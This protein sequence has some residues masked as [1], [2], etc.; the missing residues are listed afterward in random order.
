MSKEQIAL[1]NSKSSSGQRK[2][3][4]LRLPA[5]LITRRPCNSGRENYTSEGP[6]GYVSQDYQLSLL[7]LADKIVPLTTATSTDI[8]KGIRVQ[9]SIR[10][11][12]TVPS[13]LHRSYHRRIFATRRISDADPAIC[14]DEPSDIAGLV[15][16]RRID[17]NVARSGDCED[18][19]HL[20]PHLCKLENKVYAKKLAELNYEFIAK[21]TANCAVF[22]DFH[23]WALEYSYD[24]SHIKDWQRIHQA[25]A[26]FLSEHTVHQDR[27]EQGANG[28]AAI[29]TP[30]VRQERLALA[31]EE[32][33]ALACI[34]EG[35]VEP[36]TTWRTTP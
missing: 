31:N 4:V 26:Q 10:N 19:N 9:I 28:G 30:I 33:S 20:A 17:P 36:D 29:S 22:N 24:F 16:F 23:G 1:I 2:V 32:V 21:C 12:V 14:R 11:Q 8:E 35:G 18:G 3:W 13:S 25:V 6:T 5:A 34:L 15:Q 27:E 7:L